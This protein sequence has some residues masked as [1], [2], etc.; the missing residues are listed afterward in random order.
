MCRFTRKRFPSVVFSGLMMLLLSV[1]VFSQSAQ[2]LGPEDQSKQITVTFWLKQHD[3][4]GLDELVRQMYDRNSPNYRHWLT[5][6]QYQA[7][8]APT[9]ADIAVVR[10][11]LSANNLHVVYTD[12]MN[13]AVTVRGAVADVQRASGVQIN[14]AIINGEVHRVPSG[15]PA[16]SGA[17]GKLVSVVQGLSDF[18]YQNYAQRPIDPDTGKPMAVSPLSKFGPAE[19]F[20]N[21]N[22][23]RGTQT[24]DFKTTKSGPYAIYSGARYGGP[25]TAGPPNLPP[26]GYDAPEVETAYGLT[27]LYKQKLNGTGQTIAIVDAYGSDTITTDAN[28]FAQING[29][30][31]LN[32]NNFAIFYP[33]GPTTCGNNTPTPCGWD[34][35]TSLDVEWSH[36]VAPGASIALVLALN[37]SLTY[38][39]LSDLFAIETQ[40]APVISNSWGI[41]EAEL[42]EGDPGELI[43]ENNIA[44]TAAALGISINFATG[45]YGD[46]LQAT[47]TK[48]VSMPAAA[49]Y[50]TGVGGTSM[51]LNSNHSI[52]L[53]TGWGTNLTRIAAATPNPPLIPPDF[54]GFY[55]GAGG[56]A[57]GYWAKP[58]YQNG[59]SG[60][61]RLVP[62]ISYLADP[63]TG[64]EIIDTEA[65][66]G[67]QFI[68]VY[69]G[70]SLA[71]PM[72][73]AMWAI[74]VQ[75][76]GTWLGQAAP[77]LYTL[78]A[79]A[80]TDVVQQ[81]GPNNVSG[82]T[83]T[84]PSAPVYYSPSELL[85][86]VQTA[87]FMGLLY[88]GTST[89]WYA[90]GFGT[91]SSLTTGPGWDD[92]TG[93]GTPNG[94]SFVSAVAGDK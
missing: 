65:I 30:P 92:V 24:L 15:E 57:S 33:T 27:S 69:G 20:F 58:S 49:P 66:E 90:I 11:Y 41:P 4:A 86:P 32:D 72:F 28:T 79:D 8:F 21:D 85:A 47:G 52:E 37:N 42:I 10:D 16:V 19:K 22:C 78:P 89:R 75:S 9:T 51:F 50:A 67:G 61:W 18:A 12:K 48:T 2:I 94:A 55:F 17:A 40:I 83:V 68:A 71:T 46:Y 81:E 73:S 25:I 64:V 54:F 59:L 7:R 13:H 38:L 26:C 53:Q 1:P 5:P 36:S 60:T 88:N 3:K 43:V 23:L 63:Y 93:L 80:I 84:P 39:D 70:T 31:A 45:D 77:L 14:R 29:L 35:E 44:E 62:D 6:Q 74:S 82:F 76:A 91:D 34:T 87:E 56:G